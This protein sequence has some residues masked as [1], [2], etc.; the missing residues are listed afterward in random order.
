MFANVSRNL[1]QQWMIISVSAKA[2]AKSKGIRLTL[3]DTVFD[4]I[5]NEFGNKTDA[6]R[7]ALHSLPP[8]RVHH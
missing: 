5:K 7:Y 6:E 8:T 4:K 3:F 2:Q 1:T